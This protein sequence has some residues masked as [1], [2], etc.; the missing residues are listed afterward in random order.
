MV[1]K[2]NR[3]PGDHRRPGI[4]LPV[5]AAILCASLGSAGAPSFA[6]SESTTADKNTRPA[7]TSGLLDDIHPYL[8]LHAQTPVEWYPWGPEAL[9]K[10]KC[11]N[12]P[13]FVSIG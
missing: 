9:A 10:A 13:F 12:R 3:R 4:G 6:A 1:G 5:V 2:S 8:L 11:E 7:L